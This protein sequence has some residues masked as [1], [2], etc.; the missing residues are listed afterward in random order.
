MA[1]VAGCGGRSRGWGR[2]GGG[3][4]LLG[5]VAALAVAGC[6]E[7]AGDG[8][9]GVVLAVRADDALCGRLGR[10]VFRGEGRAVGEATWRASDKP[11]ELTVEDCTSW[12]LQVGLQPRGGDADRAFRVTAEGYAKGDDAQEPLVVTRVQG[13]Y[14]PGRWKRLDVTL[15]GSCAALGGAATCDAAQMCG[16]GGCEPLREVDV[17]ALP[18]VDE[19]GRQRGDA[20]ADGSEGGATDGAAGDGGMADGG[21]EGGASDGGS[22]C[23]TNAAC[24]GT[25]CGECEQPVCRDDGTCGC[26]QASVGTTCATG[27]CDGTGACVEC[28][29]D[30]HCAGTSCGECEQPVCRDDGT[31]GCAQ[32]PDETSCSC[33]ACS[34]GACAVRWLQVAAGGG[35][36]CAIAADHT[37]WCWGW[38]YLGQVGL[39]TSGSGTDVTA[40]TQVGTDMDWQ[41]VATGRTHTCAVRTDGTLWCWGDNGYGQVGQSPDSSTVVTAPTQVGTDMDWQQV[42]GGTG[43]TC[44]V[45]TDGTLWC[46]GWNDRGQ[47]GLGDLTRRSTPTQVGTATSWRQVTAGGYHGCAIQSDGTLHC[48]GLNNRGQLGQGD[49]MDRSSPAQVALDTDWNLVSGG[50]HHNCG[51]RSGV[52]RLLCWG[53]NNEGQLGID[54]SG[55]A[56]R[57][58]ELGTGWAQVS[59]GRRHTCGVRNDRTLWC[60]GA[61][62]DGALGVGDTRQR[63]SP[64]RVGMDANWQQVAAGEG[65]TCAL[66]TDGTMS[67]WGDNTYGQL[68][69]GDSGATTGRTEPTALVPPVCAP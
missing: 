48:W 68:G 55:N 3:W 2:F 14:A 11:V 65:H 21:S 39:G 58:V 15:Y 30:A 54:A 25:S 57:P 37:L 53:S 20:G 27:Y 12:P 7:D 23:T 41:Q 59:A 35:H 10:V 43:H 36:T 26:A 6:S 28:V 49:T 40:P 22:G 51:I 38:N 63:R 42:A 45:R 13:Q 32:A 29:E 4:H 47:L 50:G 61:G 8:S 18:D 5:V 24:A 67:C 1:V 34:A 31:C 64:Q 46:W 9:T 44:A 19:R 56:R 16:R 17:A 66:R 33:G 69:L 62:G 60:W 52:G